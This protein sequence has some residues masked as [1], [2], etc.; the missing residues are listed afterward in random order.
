MCAR[1]ICPVG[2]PVADQVDFKRLADA[3]LS[4]A[5]ALVYAWL[6]GGKKAGHE[7]KALNPLRA[8]AREGSFSV[9][10]A[11]GRW[12]DFATD[13]KGGDLVSLYAYLFHNSDQLAAARELAQQLGMP[14]AVPAP[15]GKGRAKP[16]APRPAP[17]SKKPE[18]VE[19]APGWVVVMPAPADAPPP[20]R[21]HEFRGV[22]SATWAYR[23]AAGAVLGYIYR[24]TTSDGGKE[25][26]PLTLWR[27]SDTGALKW[28]WAQWPEP[29]PL[30]GLDQLAA[31]PDAAVLLVEGEK[32][33]DAAQAE[34]PHLVVVSWP[35]GSKAI[36]KVDWQPLAGR[37]VID[38]ADCDCKRA[39]LTRA[40]VEAGGDPL[41][42]PLLPED[43][44]P[45]VLAMAR[46]RE[47][48]GAQ[49][50]KWWRV[51]IP[52][53]GEVPD[54][55]DVADAIADGLTGEALAGWIRER[56]EAWS[57][58]PAEPAQT[59]LD[60]TQ[61][62]AGGADEPPPDDRPE[63]PEPY[64][65]EAWRDALRYRRGEVDDC[66]AN[67][68]DMLAHRPEWVGVLAWDEFSLRTVKLKAPPYP[69]GR[70]G[71]WSDW[72][73][74]QTAIW[75]TRN[76]SI[77]PSTARVGEAVEALA[78]S[79]S[80]HPVRD[81]LKSLPPWDGVPRLDHWL[82]E[83]A[84]VELTPF[85][86]RVGRWFLMGMVARV[87]QPGCKFDYCLVLEGTQGK[88]KSTI[89]RVLGGEWFDDTD[90]TLENKDAMSS[91]QGVWLH[92]VSE[93]GALARS[94]SSRQ[95]SF[96]SRM[97][98][99]YRP[100]YGKRNIKAPRQLAFGGTT[101]EWEWNKDPTGGRRFWPVMC[102]GE[103]RIDL[104]QAAR[105]QLFA[106]AQHRY[107]AGEAFWPSPDEQRTICDPE[108]LKREQSDG[109]VDEL[110]DW[111][112]A[113]YTDF[114]LA[115][116]FGA[117]LKLDASKMTRD[118]Q[119]RVGIALRKLGCTRVE[120]RNGMT[121]FW[122]KPPVRNEASSEPVASAQPS[123]HQKPVSLAGGKHVSF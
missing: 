41:A 37:R 93:M 51:R 48:I 29:R 47:L 23:D 11:N 92:E 89:F 97:V 94:E 56:V 108:Q 100:V 4:N 36:A 1:W 78:K 30:Y 121:R 111:V 61:A 3:A 119:T 67:V 103:I 73:D 49:A 82:H 110:H 19:D 66:L 8:D 87:M 90:L 98:D 12:G 9:N 74:S 113:R 55:W 83:C 52:A 115:E 54:G 45:G 17:V 18:P 85:T 88:G 91:L 77:A 32:C 70:P 53:P 63:P 24:F 6:P 107:A 21:A 104:L 86:Q 31:N 114:S 57:A 79:N 106:E 20:P 60:A 71:E 105:E 14:D 38:W 122:Y 25:I 40:E 76:E 95:K 39:K 117:A 64:D 44:Q 69:N 102:E 101:N 13:D 75:L 2:L 81:W 28:R 15:K 65:A 59:A 109:L 7:F 123:A 72:D 27:H 33:K 26:T 42:Q 35:G 118:L 68:Y 10:L 22:P 84:G 5:E 46:I 50:A 120:K 34:L 116:V 16:A 62:G 96:L 80:I 58:T 99:N 43:E 112:Y